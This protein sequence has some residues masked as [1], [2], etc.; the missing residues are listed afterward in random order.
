MYI[1]IHDR[2][3]DIF[4]PQQR[5]KDDEKWSGRRDSNSRPP[6]PKPGALARL[7]Y[8]PTVKFF[9]KGKFKKGNCDIR[10]SFFY[11][12]REINKQPH[13]KSTMKITNKKTF[14]LFTL[15]TL[16]FR[17][18]SSFAWNGYDYD[19]KTEIEI[20]PG[21][22]VREGS[23]FQFYDSKMDNYRTGKILFMDSVAGGTR[24]QLQDLDS[25]KER[26]FIMKE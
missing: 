15:L 8:A 17:I 14:L 11:S 12:R 7:R 24:L 13:Q 18:N 25:K 20:G 9:L 19:N 10:V 2:L 21:N 6:G 22:L 5:S 1:N 26:T 3:K 23:I 4:Q 16:I